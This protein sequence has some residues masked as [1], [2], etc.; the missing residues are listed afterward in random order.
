MPNYSSLFVYQN[1]NGKCPFCK[2]FFDDLSEEQRAVIIPVFEL[3]TTQNLGSLIQRRIIKH[4]GKGLL[5]LRISQFHV[6]RVFIYYFE[7]GRFLILHGYDKRRFSGKRR[8]QLEIREARN[9]LKLWKMN[10]R[11]IEWSFR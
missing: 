4:L 6:L 10:C 9:R 8:Q 11:H 1:E 5:E 3:V 7:S 2:W